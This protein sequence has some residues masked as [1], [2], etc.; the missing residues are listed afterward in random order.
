MSAAVATP[1]TTVDHHRRPPTI[2]RNNKPQPRINSRA[3]LDT[4]SFSGFG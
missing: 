4:N 1:K 3:P 2:K